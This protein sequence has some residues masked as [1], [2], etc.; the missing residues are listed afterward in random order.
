ME[1]EFTFD[2]ICITDEHILEMDLS[3]G[4]P[5]VSLHIGTNGMRL[6][7]GTVGPCL[8]LTS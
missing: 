6:S 1:E 3:E 8:P 5:T 2:I 4:L 7:D